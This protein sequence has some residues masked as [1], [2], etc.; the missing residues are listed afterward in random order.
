MNDGRSFYF[1]WVS[2]MIANAGDVLYIVGLIQLVYLSSGSVLTLTLIPLTITFSRLIGSF[3]TPLLLHRFPLR[4]ILLSSMFG[5]VVVLSAVFFMKE[6]A[7][8]WILLLVSM[9]AFLD[10]W[11]SPV[12]QAML[13]E[14]AGK[15]SLPKANSLVAT[16]DNTVNLA[17]WPIGAFFVALVGGGPLLL[18]TISLYLVGWL[19]TFGIKHIPLLKKEVPLLKEQLSSGWAYSFSHP[20]IRNILILD[21]LLAFTG[22]VWISAI[23]YV[24]VEDV[25]DKSAAW[26]GYINAFFSGGCLIGGVIFYKLAK[27]P[28]IKLIIGG[29][30]LTG[31]VTV[32]F[33]HPVFAV[34][35]LVLSFL[36]GVVGQLQG[37]AHLTILQTQTESEQLGA[38]FSAQEVLVTAAFGI[39]TLMFGWL[40]ESFGIDLAFYVSA[41]LSVGAGIFAFVQRKTL[42]YQLNE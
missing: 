33:I 25:L 27:L 38:V 37:I 4:R 22:A 20:S 24:Y 16:S 10:G 7:I 18:I 6:E 15:E 2:Q 42:Y 19:L 31:I 30:I 41:F 32:W 34:M 26:W 14:F 29:S 39:S 21:S 3:L 8:V 23:L 35:A 9:N 28:A 12:R 36:L 17:S 5:K 13:P 1:L 11:A 40:A